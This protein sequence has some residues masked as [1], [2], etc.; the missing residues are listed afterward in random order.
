MCHSGGVS[1]Q[2]DGCFT[3]NRRHFR[4]GSKRDMPAQMDHVRFGPNVGSA[5]LPEAV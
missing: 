2:D 4:S 3:P 1:K 5:G